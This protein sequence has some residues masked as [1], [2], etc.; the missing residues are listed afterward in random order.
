MDTPGAVREIG[1]A[2]GEDGAENQ[3][4]FDGAS[5]RGG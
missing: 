3:V 1:D 5:Q 2:V 4:D